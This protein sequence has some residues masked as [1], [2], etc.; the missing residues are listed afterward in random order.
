MS[1]PFRSEKT[2]NK[3]YNLP[4]ISMKGFANPREDMQDVSVQSEDPQ[5][6]LPFDENYITNELVSMIISR[7][8]IFEPTCLLYDM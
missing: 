6:S 4:L 5:D 7:I 8:K 2:T 3:F 1:D